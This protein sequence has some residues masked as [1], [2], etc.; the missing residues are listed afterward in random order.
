MVHYCYKKET[1]QVQK[2]WF[3]S[4]DKAGKNTGFLI[5]R[6]PFRE[7]QAWTFL[8]DEVIIGAQQ[9]RRRPRTLKSF[10]KHSYCCRTWKKKNPA[11]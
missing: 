3:F 11:P 2:T 6:Q 10:D 8:R 1:L 5:E 7:W 4:R 9:M